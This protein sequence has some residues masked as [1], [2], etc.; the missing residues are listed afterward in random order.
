MAFLRGNNKSNTIKGT[1]KRDWIFARDGDDDV[2]GGDGNDVIFS[3]RGNDTVDGGNGNDFILSGRGDDTVDGGDG[4]DIISAGRGNDDVDGGDGNDHI[5]AGRGNDI[6]RG[7]AGNDK[8]MAG[9]GNDTVIHDALKNIDS[10][11]YY[12]GGRGRD[13]LVLQITQTMHDDAVFQTEW[14]Q[15]QDRINSGRAVSGKFSSLNVTFASFEN[16]Q[17]E[18]INSTPEISIAHPDAVIEGDSGLSDIVTVA[19]AE[20]VSISDVDPD[21][22]HTPYAGALAFVEASG[23]QSP[24][25]LES[26]FALDTTTGTISFD[27]AHLDYLN[28]NETVTATFSFNASSGPD[29]LVQTI[30]VTI[31]GANDAPTVHQAIDD[32][33][34]DEDTPW[35]FIIDEETFNDVDSAVLTLTAT[36]ADGN[37]LPDWLSFDGSKLTGTPPQDY[38]GEFNIKITAKDGGGKTVETTFT[39]TVDAINDAPI[40]HKGI[41]DHNSDEDTFL[42]LII[43]AD[44]FMDVDSALSR[45]IATLADG[46]ALPDWLT[47][48]GNTISGTPPTN[49]NGDLD[50]KLT[51]EDDHGETAEAIFKLVIDPV[52]DAPTLVQEFDHQNSDEDTEWEFFVPA[53]TFEDVDGESLVLTATHSDDRPLDGWL[54]FENGRFYGTPPSD[55]HGTFNLK[56][57]ATDA[58]GES[59]EV[60]F[61]LKINSIN[62]LPTLEQIIGDQNSDE[63][64]AWEFIIPAGTFNDVETANL[65][66]SAGLA[67]GSDLPGWLSFDGAGF[68]GTPPPDFNGVIDIKVIAEDEDGGTAEVVFQVTINPVNDA[69]VVHQVIEGQ[70]SDED[71]EWEF[72]IHEDTFRDVDS[73]HL[74]LSATLADGKGL[75][76]WLSFDGSKLTATPPQDY[77]GEFNIKITAED[78]GGKTAETTFTVTVDPVNDAPIVHRGIGRQIADEDTTWVFTVPSDAFKDIDSSELT[79]S[80]TFEDGAPLPHWIS[81]ENDTFTANP[82]ADHNGLLFLKVTATDDGGQT[83]ETSFIYDIRPINDL[84]DAPDYITGPGLDDIISGDLGDVIFDV[85][86]DTVIAL[87]IDDVKNGTLAFSPDGKYTYTPNAGFE[88][89]DRFTYSAFDG[90]GS[91]Q[92]ATVVLRTENHAP[93]ANDDFVVTEVNKAVEIAA[94]FNDLDEDG[95]VLSY[96]SVGDAKFG[97]VSISSA[98]KLLYTPYEGQFG[99]DE[100]TYTVTDGLETSTATV[101]V[102]FGDAGVFGPS[103]DFATTT[104]NQSV[105]INVSAND[106]E[107]NGHTSY[108]FAMRGWR[109]GQLRDLNGVMTSVNGGTIEY[110][111]PFTLG[112]PLIFEEDGTVIYTPPEDFVGIDEFRYSILGGHPFRYVKVY[113]NVMSV[114]GAP[115]ARD[116][117]LLVSPGS[118]VTVAPLENDTIED[119]SSS[120]IDHTYAGLGQVQWSSDGT[121]LY[122]PADGFIG[123]DWINY[124]VTNSE[125]LSDSATV[126]I[127]VDSAPVA[128][129]DV[130]SVDENREIIIDLLQNDFDSE[131]DP[132]EIISVGNATNGTVTRNADGTVTYVNDDGFTGQD[133]FTYSISDGDQETTATVTVDV[134]ANA[135]PDAVDDTFIIAAGEQV[136]DVLSNDMDAENDALSVVSVSD[137]THGVVTLV[138]GNVIYTANHGFSGQDSFTYTTD[139]GGKTDTATVN[140]TVDLGAWSNLQNDEV[141]VV[142]GQSVSFNVLDNDTDPDGDNLTVTETTKAAFGTVTFNPDGTI[143]YTAREGF[144]GYDA[145]TYYVSDGIHTTA[146]MVEV[147]VEAGDAGIKAPTN[148]FEGTGLTHTIGYESI[149]W[150]PGDTESPYDIADSEF[151]FVV[152]TDDNPRILEAFADNIIPFHRENEPDLTAIKVDMNDLPDGVLSFKPSDTESYRIEIEW[153]VSDELIKTINALALAAYDQEDMVDLDQGPF[154]QN[155]GTRNK[156]TITADYIYSQIFDWEQIPADTVYFNSIQDDPDTSKDDFYTPHNDDGYRTGVDTVQDPI[157]G[158]D[159]FSLGAGNAQ[160]RT[161]GTDS[162]SISFRGTD[163]ATDYLSDNLL[164]LKYGGAS[165]YS[166]DRFEPLLNAVNLYLAANQQITNVYINGHSLGGHIVNALYYAVKF[167]EKWSHLTDALFIAQ[168]APT[169]PEFALAE[170]YSEDLMR[171]YYAIGHENDFIYKSMHRDLSITTGGLLLGNFVST[172]GIQP[173]RPNHTN[174]LVYIEQSY[175]HARYPERGED[176]RLYLSSDSSFDSKGSHKQMLTLDSAHRRTLSDKETIAEYGREITGDS[177]MYIIATG[178]TVTYDNNKATIFALWRDAID[179]NANQFI[180]ALD[181]DGDGIPD[182]YGFEVFNYDISTPPPIGDHTD[183]EAAYTGLLAVPVTGAIDTDGD[184]YVDDIDFNGDGIGDYRTG[185]YTLEFNHERAGGSNYRVLDEVGVLGL[186]NGV[187]FSDIPVKNIL[188]LRLGGDVVDYINLYE[189]IP[190]N[191]IVINHTIHNEGVHYLGLDDELAGFSLAESYHQNTSVIDANDHIVAGGGD[192]ILEGLAGDDILNG[193]GGNDLILGGA[194]SDRMIGGGGDDII[195]GWGNSGPVAENDRVFTGK[196]TPVTIDVLANDFDLDGDALTISDIRVRIL[197]NQTNEYGHGTVVVNDNG[198]LTYTPQDG[199]YGKDAFVYQITDG[200]YT[201]QALVSVIVDGDPGDTNHS[202][203]AVWETVNTTMGQGLYYDVLYNDYHLGGQELRLAGHGFA[204][205]PQHGTATVVGDLQDGQILYTPDPGFVGRDTIEYYLWDGGFSDIGKLTINVGTPAAYTQVDTAVYLGNRETFAIMRA[206]GDEDNPVI[207]IRDLDSAHG[208]EGTDLVRDVDFVEFGDMTVDLATLW[209]EAVDVLPDYEAQARDDI[210]DGGD[211]DNLIVGGDGND[212]LIGGGGDDTIYGGQFVGADPDAYAAHSDGENLLYGGTGDDRIIGGLQ[213]DII[214][215]G[216]DNDIIDVTPYNDTAFT[217]NDVVYGGAGDDLITLGMGT[218]VKAYGDEGDDTI[219]AGTHTHT[220]GGDG[221]DKIYG[222]SGHDHS[223]GGAGDDLIEGNGGNDFLNGAEGDDHIYGGG[224]DD[225]LN[226]NEDDDYLDGGNGS[227]S[228]TGGAGDDTIQGGTYIDN[229]NPGVEDDLSYGIVDTAIFSG[230]ISDYSIVAID[231]ETPGTAF[232]IRDLFAFDGDDGTDTV[233]GIEK[234]TFADGTFLGADVAANYAVAALQDVPVEVAPEF[235]FINAVTALTEDTDTSARTK[236]ADIELTDMGLGKTNFAI[237]GPDAGLFEIDGSELFLKAGTTL[238]HESNSEFTVTL[239][240]DDPNFG[241]GIDDSVTLQIAITDIDEA[242]VVTVSDTSS[243]ARANTPNGTQLAHVIAIDP[244]D[245]SFDFAITAGNNDADGDGRDVFVVDAYGRILLGDQDDLLG[246]F[247]SQVELE[248]EVTSTAFVHTTSVFI[249]VEAIA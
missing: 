62:D 52:N 26:L 196:S 117:E 209:N 237:Q 221:I 81:F 145:F 45:P 179:T 75:P 42:S 205:S 176:W 115:T 4:D 111:N 243:A 54:S 91:S 114:D 29:T 158:I 21:D 49:F 3:G 108:P 200:Q 240:A 76:G 96:Q 27:R 56:V 175:D 124:T 79:L 213:S 212:L 222:G 77:N 89:V 242:P 159:L 82:P 249:D 97:T 199:F 47:V 211:G 195:I 185:G 214:Y 153:S 18:I 17:I 73:T 125:G 123:I 171:N 69:P 197:D 58:A 189:Y 25:G 121:F 139:D 223:Y 164:A 101:T 157:F 236:I 63:D 94:L 162:L 204:R 36:L 224:S 51:V 167:Q 6:I 208:N 107:E 71:T 133:S 190:T 218:G 155:D 248:V 166:A 53:G 33:N 191:E 85:D 112:T 228:L 95:D 142:Q 129:D 88:G 161:H 177:P 244:D 12:H 105:E 230:L 130:V 93:T 201:A 68:S 106:T 146:A 183:Y 64:T 7:G 126:T 15:F 231:G 34:S 65:A 186:E 170:E 174:N 165:S 238:N 22:M 50:I 226:G 131:N 169:T 202:G 38:N 11:D 225:T 35:E 245:D 48:E 178:D 172:G 127:T 128:N 23:P 134:L 109:D 72:T 182:I 110:D 60:I 1:G 152:V 5:Y 9:H 154:G 235:E 86:N 31:T 229:N 28:D 216:D 122:T 143:S 203:V 148:L 151:V 217:E 10:H 30:I 116:E 163:Q 136:L 104:K 187:W 57:I 193:G 90:I 37:N 19:V 180:D 41:A 173:D 149:W 210:V 2:D 232:Q 66:L 80:A 20:H 67:D 246:L 103:P 83:A 99:T 140:V 141:S 150:G 24:G 181:T 215:G 70:N 87:L 192:D 39:V 98:G 59:A 43:P 194:G 100:I 227:D 207:A 198:T 138:N 74:T 102:T 168:S 32:Q 13:T 40:V 247:G 219:Y 144:S 61:Q 113:V 239:T 120:T 206:S 188:A 233:Y 137:A 16:I 92:P 241:A 234:L 8:I 220:Y 46:S 147:S 14:A 78:G 84:P 184:G 135:A 44:I 156:Q 119:L 160:V 118:S 132:V 55:F